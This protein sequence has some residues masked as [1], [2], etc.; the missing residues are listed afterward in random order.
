[1]KTNMH[2]RDFLATS[3]AALAAS[4]F[5]AEAPPQR[6]G[7]PLEQEPLAYDFN[8][9]EPFI[10]AKTMEI[11]YT[12]HHAAYVANL[13][14]AL[15]AVHLEAASVSAL[16]RTMDLLLP[17][18]EKAVLQLKQGMQ[19]L[20]DDFKDAVRNFGGG[21]MNHTIFWR[22]MAPAGSVPAEPQGQLADAIM[23]KFGD[24]DGFKKAFTEAALKQF[25]SG[26]AWLAYH[27]KNGLFISTTPNQDNPLMKNIVPDAEYGRPVLCLDLWEH[28]Y[29]L[30][31][32]NRR[33]DYIA[34]WWN[35]VNWPR[36]EKS[37][38]IVTTTTS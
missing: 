5:S 9:L 27:E 8:A 24:L 26:W 15:D 21:H 18:G 3:G 20:P 19:N 16:I 36:V 29:Y 7:V 14:K 38:G 33:A 12:K 37:Y 32:Q 17:Q 35:V 13:R 4:A 10:D 23:T 34:A 6:S 25:G 22:F 2:R 28:A 30:K 31:Y 1:M 11:H